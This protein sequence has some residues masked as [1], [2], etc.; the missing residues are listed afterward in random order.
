MVLILPSL[1]FDGGKSCNG[2]GLR[3]RYLSTVIEFV[4][5]LRQAQYRR[6]FQHVTY[7]VHQLVGQD[8]YQ[9][10]AEIDL[11]VDFLPRNAMGLSTSRQPEGA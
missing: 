11:A 9:H 10:R 6:E 4:R 5:P 7:I 8:E 2:S 3:N 1:Q